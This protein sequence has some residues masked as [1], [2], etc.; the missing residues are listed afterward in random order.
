MCAERPNHLHL[1][2]ENNISDVLIDFFLLA[3]LSSC[4]EKC[5]NINA[6]SLVYYQ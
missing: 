6:F 5:Y 4:M 3:F 2:P 1:S